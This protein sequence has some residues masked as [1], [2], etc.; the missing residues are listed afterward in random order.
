MHFPLCTG[1]ND[2]IITITLL[3]F[4]K[5]RLQTVNCKCKAPQYCNYCEKEM[6]EECTQFYVN[7][8]EEILYLRDGLQPEHGIVFNHP[9]IYCNICKVC[10]LDDFK[11]FVVIWISWN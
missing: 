3:E 6:N 1:D 4:D 10:V 8:E 5:T 9:F 2:Y 7:S 11:N